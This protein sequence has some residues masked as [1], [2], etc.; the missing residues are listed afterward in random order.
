MHHLRA[1]SRSRIDPV[2]LPRRTRPDGSEASDSGWASGSD[3]RLR[4]PV[5][6]STRSRRAVS[7]SRFTDSCKVRDTNDCR[8]DQERA[9]MAELAEASRKTTARIVWDTADKYLRNVVDEE[10]YGDYIL[11]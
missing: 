3:R 6:W 8:G 5:P 11:P 4:C 7:R 9:R 10:D 1:A 2:L